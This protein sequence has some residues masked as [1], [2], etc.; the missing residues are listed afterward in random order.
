[1]QFYKAGQMRSGRRK[2]HAIRAA[3]KENETF[4]RPIAR[5][6]ELLVRWGEK[7]TGEIDD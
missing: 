4:A 5:A 1:M 3:K 2:E 6:G 7:T